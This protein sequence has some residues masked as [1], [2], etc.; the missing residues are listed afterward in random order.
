MTGG[1]IPLSIERRLQALEHENEQLRKVVDQ[2]GRRDAALDMQRQLWIAKT[3]AVSSYPSDPADTFGI[4]FQDGEY[5]RTE[6]SPSPTYGDRSLA[7]LEWAKS[8]AGNYYAEGT[9]VVVM[10]EDRQ[11]WI[12]DAA[13][14][15]STDKY[16][17]ISADEP[18]GTPSIGQYLEDQFDSHS[19]TEDFNSATD[20]QMSTDT[21]YTGTPPTHTDEHIRVYWSTDAV[22]CYTPGATELLIHNGAQGD[23][24]QWATISPEETPT[25]SNSDRDFFINFQWDTV[26]ATCKQLRGFIDAT[27]SNYYSGNDIQMW[28]HRDADAQWSWYK[29]GL[30]GTYSG[31]GDYIARVDQ[32]SVAGDFDIYLAPA[33]MVNG[34]YAAGSDQLLGHDVSGFF[35]WFAKTS[36]TNTDY[37][38]AINSADMAGDLGGY[39]DT[40]LDN[41]G[42]T[43]VATDDLVIPWH[44][45]NAA[46][47]SQK[48]EYFIDASAQTGGD[49][50]TISDIQVLGH[51][52]TGAWGWYDPGKTKVSSTDALAYLESQF[53]DTGTYA[54]ASDFP[55]RIDSAGNTLKLFARPS[56]ETTGWSTGTDQILGHDTLDQFTWFAK[57][58]GADT[59]YRFTINAESD[60]GGTWTT[61]IVGE[62]VYLS[63]EDLQIDWD[64]TPIGKA[65]LFLD[66]SAQTAGDTHS[67][68][69]IQVLGHGVTGAWGWYDPC[70]VKL[71][72]GDSCG[73]LESKL[74][75]LG[76]KNGTEDLVINW[77]KSTGPLVDN[78]VDASA[79]ANWA[80]VSG[81]KYLTH[82]GGQWTWAQE[83]TGGGG[84]DTDYRFEINSADAAPGRWD[85]K[86]NGYKTLASVDLNINWDESPADKATL[87]VDASAIV[88]FAGG[89]RRYL[90]HSGTIWQWVDEPAGGTDTDYRFAIT[91]ADGFPGRWDTKVQNEAVYVAVEDLAIRWDETPSG[92]ATLFIDASL[93]TGFA[94]SSPRYLVHQNGQF[95]W[96]NE[97]A[98]INTDSRFTINAESEPGGTWKQKIVGEDVYIDSEDLPIDWDETPA[99]QATMFIDADAIGGFLLSGR[100]YLTHTGLIWEW[101][102]EPTGGGGTPDTCLVLMNSSMTDCQY[103]DGLFNSTDRDNSYASTADLKIDWYITGSGNAQQIRHYIDADGDIVGYVSSD[104]SLG[105]DSNGIWT[106]KN[107]ERVAPITS[108]RVNEATNPPQFEYKTTGF[109]VVDLEAESAWIPWHVGD[110]CLTGP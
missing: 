10:E 77:R 101:V 98:M 33:D 71:D 25:E 8:I 95:E 96:V 13:A 85:T 60:P 74:D 87:F 5:A 46:T 26:A 42:G 91:A 27:D 28:G 70:L 64:E 63:T 53:T 107:L 24:P 16:V 49:S 82:Y 54:A 32:V 106:W 72:S 1:T 86:V 18:T 38:V 80:T 61:K 36:V 7:P 110:K 90:T 83:P 78:F 4:I 94:G 109:K 48:V 102:Q 15:S 21:K 57:S 97:P 100:K 108:I 41:S 47:A 65:T 50:W 17:K 52:I 92:A 22:A 2:L 68:A 30:T 3:A 35:K 29:W 39:L 45:T 89:G 55:L 37:R 11:Y 40:K 43:Y 79:I 105:H 73:L 58:S 44:L 84:T 75:N 88:G 69:V 104:Q 31:S 56:D 93:I 59:D 14:A 19:A 12:I 103:L 51:G 66:A 99:G 62:D 76:V 81:R 6:G 34:P 20:V 23:E 9:Y 67:T